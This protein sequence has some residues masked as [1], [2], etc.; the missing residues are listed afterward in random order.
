MEDYVNIDRFLVEANKSDRYAN[1]F[2]GK[3]GLSW[4]LPAGAEVESPCSRPPFDNRKIYRV[5]NYGF[6]GDN[7]TKPTEILI[8]GCSITYGSGLDEDYIWG[9]MLAK[10]LNASYSNVG[11]SGA[12][13]QIIV[14]N[15]IGYLEEIGHVSSVYC[16]FPDMHRFTFPVDGNLVSLDMSPLLESTMSKNKTNFF[17]TSYPV[18]FSEKSSPRISKRPHDPKDI[19]SQEL[20]IYQSFLAARRLEDY[21]R[22]HEIKLLWTTWHQKT[23]QILDVAVQS[24]KDIKFKDYFSLKPYNGYFNFKM[25]KPH[26]K[27]IQTDKYDSVC[28]T[29]HQKIECS[30]YSNCHTEKEA[31]YEASGQ[32]HHALDIELDYSGVHPGI[33]SHLHILEGFLDQI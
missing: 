4:A 28:R 11:L 24:R 16:L 8:A 30:C 18:N 25:A 10:K 17:S 27:Y 12:S 29:E 20:A 33:H 13:W 22:L 19:F 6:R 26:Y 5:N 15:I 2:F 23:S 14:D 21:C 7:F 31:A 1:Q 9:S 3:P 32:F